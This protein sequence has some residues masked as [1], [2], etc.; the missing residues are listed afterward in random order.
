MQPNS[1]RWSPIGDYHEEFHTRLQQRE[2]L[3]RYHGKA[4]GTGRGGRHEKLLESN[5]R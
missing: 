4:L 3:H 5:C 2:R 1:E